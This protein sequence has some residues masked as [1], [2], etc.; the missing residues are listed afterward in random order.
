MSK[1]TCCRCERPPAEWDPPGLLVRIQVGVAPEIPAHLEP[2]PPEVRERVS[3]IAEALFA[4]RAVQPSQSAIYC[5]AC[6]D[7]VASVAPE[8]ATRHLRDEARFE[9]EDQR[10]ARGRGRAK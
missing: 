3:G 1:Y 4:K 5:A 2:T 8:E 6:W 10:R 7:E 9:M